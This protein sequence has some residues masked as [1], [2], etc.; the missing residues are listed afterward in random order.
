MY[1]E[2]SKSQKKIARN[3]MD[4]G[5]EQHYNLGLK[6]IEKILQ[7]WRDGESGAKDSYMM[8]LFEKLNRID[9]N[10]SRIYDGKGG[11][12]WVEVM[13]GQ[14]ADGVIGESDLDEFEDEV[15][16]MIISYGEFFKK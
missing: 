10:I 2:L 11:S 14:Y 9:K 6:E 4:K 8:K 7:K 12:R 5:I 13:A 15:K 1:F 16:Q 3:V